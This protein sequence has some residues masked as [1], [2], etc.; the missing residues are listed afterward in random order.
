MAL[1]INTDTNVIPTLFNMYVLRNI[2][3]T[4]SYVISMI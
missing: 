2:Y 4:V 1:L 3:L